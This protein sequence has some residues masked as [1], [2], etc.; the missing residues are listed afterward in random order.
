MDFVVV[1]AAGLL[2]PPPDF[3]VTALTFRTVRLTWS[4]P[5]TLN[6]T[7]NAQPSIVGYS[8]QVRNGSGDIVMAV[9][10]TVIE[11]H[12]TIVECQVAAYQVCVAGINGVGTGLHSPLS[13]AHGCECG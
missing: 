2:A 13:L 1:V 7:R 10:L 3:T 12:Y 8:I 5:H 9:N 4:P 6:V 11:Y